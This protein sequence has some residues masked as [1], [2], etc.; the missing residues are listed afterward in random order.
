VTNEQ[1]LTALRNWFLSSIKSAEQYQPAELEQVKE[2][3]LA[4]NESIQREIEVAATPFDGRPMSHDE[5]VSR[6]INWLIS[7]ASEPA[8]LTAEEAV[9]ARE[10]NAQIVRHYEKDVQGG[11]YVRLAKPSTN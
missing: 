9:E 8:R 7:V 5:F 10:L 11:T 2:L 1:L 6:L 3:F 4:V